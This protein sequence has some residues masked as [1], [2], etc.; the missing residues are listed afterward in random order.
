MSQER[1]VRT[2][3]GYAITSITRPEPKIDSADATRGTDSK[4]R[5]M[6]DPSSSQSLESQRAFNAYMKRKRAA[7]HTVSEAEL[8]TAVVRAL[9]R[10]LDVAV[11][12]HEAAERKARLDALN[13]ELDELETR[14]T[15]EQCAAQ[16]FARR[17]MGADYE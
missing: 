12:Q 4:G 7:K 2:T 11:E 16:V 10:K 13:A 14:T 3:E 5:L 17:V 1:E 8:M 6:L 9:H 15:R